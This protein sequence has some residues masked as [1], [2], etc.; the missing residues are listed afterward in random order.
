MQ[1]GDVV[2]LEV[3]GIAH[4]GVFVARREGMVVFVPDAVPGETLRA[5]VT[6]QKKSFARAE[7]LEVLDASPHRRPHVWAEADIARD[8]RR[9]V[10]GADLGHI[11][12]V[13]Q[14]ALKERVLREAFERFAGGAA[15]VSVSAAAAEGAEE[16][17][18]GTRWRTRIGLHVDADGRIGPFAARSH[19]VVEVAGHPLATEAVERAAL[20]LRGE[21]PGRVD[22][23]H[24]SDGDVRIV[25]RPAERPGGGSRGAR[26]GARGSRGPS[27]PDAVVQ[28]VA[29]RPF[30]VETGGFW[31]VHRLAAGML[32]DAVSGSVRELLAEGLVAP[33]GLHLDLYGGVGLLADAVAAAVGDG[34]QIISVESAP[35]ATAH[36]AENLAR[37]AGADAVTARVERWLASAVVDADDDERAAIARGAVVLDPP[38]AGAGRDVVD[39][40]ADLGPAAVVYVACDPVAL[41]RDA[42]LL[43]A[44]GYAVDAVSGLDLFPN[45]HHVEAVAVFRRG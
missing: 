42:G 13:H 15:R 33:D 36:A 17:P 40:V 30:R 6:E 9:R 5:R 10:G 18:D 29:G 26:G 21:K 37:L 14:R 44:R 1:P 41:A 32:H 27:R 35:Q 45:S 25:R 19:E 4:G 34:T 2:D 24:P 12:L 7:A 22:L 43:R 23:V 31:Q 39:R 20:A 8:P 3:T 28:H 16:T 38:R 11:D